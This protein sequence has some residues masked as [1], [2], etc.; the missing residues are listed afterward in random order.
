MLK[1]PPRQDYHIV[2]R[3][4]RD[5]HEYNGADCECEPRCVLEG[6]T[7]RVFLHNNREH[8]IEVLKFRAKAGDEPQLTAGE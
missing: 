2:L 8:V 5:G 7:F 6:D 4:T 1:R 3:E